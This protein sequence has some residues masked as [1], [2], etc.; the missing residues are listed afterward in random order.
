MNKIEKT[1]RYREHNKKVINNIVTDIVNEPLMEIREEI[2]MGYFD[3]NFEITMNN[4]ED[5]CR[6]C[7]NLGLFKGFILG[8]SSAIFGLILG[9]NY[10]KRKDKIH[11]EIQSLIRSV[12]RNK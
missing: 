1:K 11:E 4:E 12:S 8:W 9:I 7:R 5:S 10:V 3:K 2:K 6:I